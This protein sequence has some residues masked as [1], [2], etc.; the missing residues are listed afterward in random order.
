MPDRP[1][2]ARCDGDTIAALSSGHPPAAI[3]VI[4]TSGPDANR[5]AEALAG[6]L[7]APRT[8]ALRT[9]RDPLSGAILDTALLI[10]FAA[11]HSATGEDIVE[12]QCHGGRA[13]VAAVLAALTSLGLRSA[14]PGEFTRRALAFGRIDFTEAE[15]LADLLE[16]ETETQRRAAQLVAGGALSR[17]VDHWRAK[18]LEL[19]ARAEAAIDYVGDEDE[20]AT[21]IDQIRGEAEAV[22]AELRDWLARPRSEPLK[23][24]IR[25]VVG[26]P[27]N[28]G[29]SS[30]IN[31][32]VGADRAIVTPIPG[33]TR[34]TIEV[35]LAIGGVPLLFVD[36][37]GIRASDDPVEII[38]VGRAIA[39]AGA[40][41]ILLW[42]GEAGLAPENARTI[43]IHP[44][45]DLGPGPPGAHAISALT[46]DGL[47]GLVKML[48]DRARHLLPAEGRV[49]LN[50]RQHA[51]VAEAAALLEG[52]PS[53]LLL[54]AETLRS[55][56]L[57]FNRLTGRAGIDD[58]LDALFGRFCLGK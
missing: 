38:G 40:S 31:A 14:A 1:A 32:L 25:V 43:L 5:A 30:L 8:A 35:P 33:T 4:R 10:R 11:P 2:S 53:D 20:T 29:K 16:A 3:A 15:G 47:P 52:L 26:G 57:A 13:V 23:E 49:A 36:T 37:A 9:L 51:L 46:G 22:G 21:D 54:L 58:A 17:Q 34:D 6:P 19:S 24:G 56:R 28:A 18:I 48:L 12:Y 39:E 27:P 50:Q 41:D 45:S 44:K 7:P 55:A 42:L